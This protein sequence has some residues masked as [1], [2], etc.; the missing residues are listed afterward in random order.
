MV[1][2]IQYIE[3]NGRGWLMQ[4][5][6]GQDW[7]ACQCCPAWCKFVPPMASIGLMNPRS[8]IVKPA[9]RSCDSGRRRCGWVATL[10]GALSPA[11]RLWAPCIEP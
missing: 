3:A 6:T 5:S 4:Q 9:R 2:A 8:L 7:S 11:R 1:A 10:V